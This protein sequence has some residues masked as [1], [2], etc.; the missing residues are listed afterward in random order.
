[1]WLILIFSFSSS[2]IQDIEAIRKAGEVD[3][4]LL[5]LF[6]GH[7][8]TMQA[9]LTHIPS[10]PKIISDIFSDYGKGHVITFWQKEML[11]TPDRRPIY[12]IIDGLDESPNA[13]GL[14][15]PREG[16]LKLLKDLVGLSLTNLHICIT[17]RSEV[18]IRH[19][20]ESLASHQ[21]SLHDQSGQKKDIAEYIRSVVYLLGFRT[22]H[23]GVEGYW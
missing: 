7:H 5:F 4:L 13:S 9:W 15:S 23:E 18:D 1:M 20:I 8:Q 14:P 17:S 10:H 12:L 6:L 3:G 2:I 11:A 16:V 22:T 21:I 19:A